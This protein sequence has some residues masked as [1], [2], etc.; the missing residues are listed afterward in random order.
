MSGD[1]EQDLCKIVDCGRPVHARGLC[2]RHYDVSRK[3]SG[4]RTQP[5]KRVVCSVAGCG[6]P[7]HAR[8]LCQIHYDELRKRVTGRADGGSAEA[9]AAASSGRVCRVPGC[10]QPHHAKGYCKRHYGQL[11]REGAVGMTADTTGRRYTRSE[12]LNVLRLRYD[13]L[14]H[15]IESIHKAF[16]AEV[17]G[18]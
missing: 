9:A 5:G 16:E 12:R 10:A 18:D 3:R 6:Q 8:G 4:K 11:C 17:N 2:Q 7:H 15:E 13:R 14:R 1:K